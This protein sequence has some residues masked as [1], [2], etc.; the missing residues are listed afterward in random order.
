MYI[1]TKRYYLTSI[2]FQV[3]L[4]HAGE[5]QNSVRVF[6]FAGTPKN[7]ASRVLIFAES[8]K[9]RKIAKF[10]TRENLVPQGTK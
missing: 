2:D 9:M 7:Y 3:Y 1:G 4:F 8:P 6:I 5:G 10:Y